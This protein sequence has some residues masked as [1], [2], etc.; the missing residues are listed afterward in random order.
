MIIACGQ[1]KSMYDVSAHEAGTPVVCKC[2]EILLVPEQDYIEGATMI[3]TYM[4]RLAE[5]EN[6]RLGTIQDAGVWEFRRG[7]AVIRVEYSPKEDQLTVGSIIMPIPE[8]VTHKVELY[9]R[10]L[11]LNHRSTGEARFATAAGNVI[12]TFSRYVTGLDYVEFHSA[13][14]SV[15]RTSDDYDD[16]L[17]ADFMPGTEGAEDEEIDLSSMK[18]G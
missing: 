7:S 1:C 6:I 4:K 2:G 5:E 12:V 16:E 10:I 3:T 15:S 18:G 13:I 8:N 17:R 11:E 9:Q 14:E